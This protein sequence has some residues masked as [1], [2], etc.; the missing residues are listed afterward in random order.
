MA[1]GR[2][3]RFGRA[4]HANF[5]KKAIDVTLG[6]LYTGG[7][8]AIVTRAVGL[9]GELSIAE[10]TFRIRRRSGAPPI[11]VAFASDFHAGPT[12]HPRLVADVL[13]AIDDAN[14]D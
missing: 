2:P 13:A 9:Q 10:H 14:A 11:R 1:S 5:K 4:R 3:R 7:W 6:L 12:L 8:P